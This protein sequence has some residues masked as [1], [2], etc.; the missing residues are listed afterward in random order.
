MMPMLRPRVVRASLR[1]WGSTMSRR[2]LSRRRLPYL[3]LASRSCGGANTVSIPRHGDGEGSSA[4]ELSC[5]EGD[6]HWWPWLQSGQDACATWSLVFVGPTPNNALRTAARSITI[7][8]T[9]KQACRQPQTVPDAG[10]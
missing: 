7:A 5:I 2:C 9:E 4:G 3:D 1:K 10:L 8:D 6:Q